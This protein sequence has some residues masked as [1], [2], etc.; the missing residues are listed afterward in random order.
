MTELSERAQKFKRT[1]KNFIL[2]Y[3]DSVTYSDLEGKAKEFASVV[4]NPPD[5]NEIEA[6]VADITIELTIKFSQSGSVVDPETFEPL[7]AERK[8]NSETPRWNAYEQLLLERDWD[9]TVIGEIDFQ[10]EEVLELVGDPEKPGEWARRGLLIG[11]VQS[12]K[13]ANYLALLNKALDFGYKV[14]IV[15]GGHTN[16]L[17]RQTQSRLD[18]DLL[19]ID[20]EY[21][22]DNIA[23]TV[24]PDIGIRNIDSDLQAH[25]KT[26]VNGDFSAKKKTA[27]ITWMNSSIPTVF[28][29][30][31]NARVIA[32]VANYIRH[33]SKDEKMSMPLLVVDDESDWG[34]PN[35]GSETDP[36]RVNKEIRRLLESSSRSSYL[37]ITA[38]PFANVF[39][40]HEAK[41]DDAG[42]DLFPKDYIRALSSPSTYAGVS[43]FFLEAHKGLRLDVADCLEAIPIVHK[44]SHQV[45]V[46][47]ASLRA[48]TISFLLGTAI[49]RRRDGGKRPASM[50]V[51]VSRFNNVQSQVHAL[52][53]GFVKQLRDMVLGEFGRVSIK[54]SALYEEVQQI[55]KQ[56]FA[57]VGEVPFSDIKATL[58]TA[59]SEFRVELVNSA[60]AADR[61]R[62][63]KSLTSAQREDR[64]LEPTIFVGGDVLSRGLTLAGLQVSYFVREPR[65]MDTLMQMGRWFG[66]QKNYAD[67][68]RLWI[69]EG[70]A[71]DFSDS[72]EVTAE[73]KQMLIEMKSRNLTPKQFGLRVRTHPEGLKI[74]AANKSRSTEVL[75]EGPMLFENRIAGSQKLSRDRKARSAN[76]DATL[77]LLASMSESSG[78]L[79]SKSSGGYHLWSGVPLDVIREYFSRFRGHPSCEVFGVPI[80]AQPA[81]ITGVI[82]DAKNSGFWDVCFVAGSGDSH[83]FPNNIQVK[84]SI[85]NKIRPEEDQLVRMLSPVTA[86]LS[87]SNSLSDDE[88]SSIGSAFPEWDAEEGY[89]NERVL[90]A[91]NRPR[92][93]VF[94][95]SVTNQELPELA[96]EMNSDDPLIAVAVVFP[97]LDP[98]EAVREAERAK[99][100]R[101]N[102]V[103]L[104]NYYSPQF[105][106]DE[107]YDEEL[108]D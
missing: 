44:N 26:T 95:C 55:W 87:L 90:S 48:A 105:D 36:T 75:H 77:Q 78:V 47:P 85:R 10:S 43:S 98:E 97:K 39:I 40:D 28:V 67:L 101:V 91:L 18:T 4:P 94:P 68:V 69:P 72:G 31:K 100:Y 42:L 38:T 60:T 37:G 15:I 23:N 57:D 83:E 71:Q 33:Q 81:T 61:R 102:T 34:T 104:Q 14:V 84:T 25:V 62:L 50:L 51:N 74:V 56:E 24:R 53:D 1:L 9:T 65:T 108:D 64:D 70:T 79:A 52:L 59:I 2:A 54:H 103:W 66:Y 8:A 6:V 41:S 20:S 13:T 30:K 7:L 35:T 80:D 16:E 12:G 19:G 46:M 107:L 106:F 29:I 89:S 17:R 58:M 76:Y 99:T 96:S 21:L 32:N 45:F 93:L 92:L 49:R 82:G 73:F 11:E 63:R 3:G 88:K 5:E 27:G 86:A 22:E